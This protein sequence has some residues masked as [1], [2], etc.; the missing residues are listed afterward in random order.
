[1]STMAQLQMVREP[2]FMPALLK[3]VGLEAISPSMA[4]W[5]RHVAALAQPP[6]ALAAIDA[7]LKVVT[8]RIRVMLGELTA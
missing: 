5:M 3:H 8:D 6:R 7:D 2:L 1:M 4:D